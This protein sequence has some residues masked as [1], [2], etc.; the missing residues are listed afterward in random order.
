MGD[1]LL[2][3]PAERVRGQASWPHLSPLTA[4]CLSARSNGQHVQC[5]AEC[6]AH[7]PQ[8]SSWPRPPGLEA[9]F[10]KLAKRITAKLTGEPGIYDLLG[11]C[12]G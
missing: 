3:V 5:V 9:T 4:H 11:P 8:R 12:P 2:A 6:A 1:L 7:L 10:P